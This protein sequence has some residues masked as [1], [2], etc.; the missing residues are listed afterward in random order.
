MTEK[1]QR[2][3][4][5]QEKLHSIGEEVSFRCGNSIKKGIIFI[6]DANGTF[7]QPNIPSYDIMVDNE[8]TLY[9][10]VSWNL[11]Y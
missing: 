2:E 3:N 6:V 4:Y 1:K 9:K 10:H 8:D 5:S 7:E 11:V